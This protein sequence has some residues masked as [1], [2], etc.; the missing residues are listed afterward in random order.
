MY[1]LYQLNRISN[2]QHLCVTP[3]PVSNDSWPCTDDSLWEIKPTSAYRDMLIYCIIN[4]NTARP[5]ETTT[6]QLGWCHHINTQFSA[7]TS[8]FISWRSWIRATWYDYE[9][10][11]Q[12]AT[13]QVNLL[14][15]VDSTCFGRCFRPSSAPDD[16]SKHRPE[17]AEPTRNNKVTCV[18]ASCWL[19]SKS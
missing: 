16:G 4:S 9:S 10:N 3:L 8:N 14:L 2:K 17:H 5:A 12:D 7:N 18:V 13:I 11:Q 6:P 15:L 19:L 1:P